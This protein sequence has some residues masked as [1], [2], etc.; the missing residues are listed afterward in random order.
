M[1]FEAAAACLPTSS[2]T[3]SVCVV[4]SASRTVMV[5]LAIS[6]IL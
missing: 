5:L 6:D 3:T 2:E 1:D 4:P